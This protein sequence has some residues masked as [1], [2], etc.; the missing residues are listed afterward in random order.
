MKE[1]VG[2]IKTELIEK[3]PRSLDLLVERINTTV[4]PPEPVTTGDVYIRAMY[5]VSDQINSYGGCFPAE[6][7]QRLIEL[8]IDSPVMV[9]HRKDQLPIARNFSAEMVQKNGVNWIKVYFYWLKNADGGD[10]L[11]R[12][13]DGGI[14]KEGSISF[15]F[16]FPECSIC[17]S[18]IRDCGHRP[19]AEYSVDGQMV[20]AY[21]NYR[22][23]VKVLETSLVYRGSISGTAITRELL[24]KPALAESEGKTEK[25]GSLPSINFICDLSVLNPGNQYFIMPAYESL[26]VQI[27]RSSGKV[28]FRDASGNL[29]GSEALGR[30][31]ENLSWPKGEYALTGRLIGYRGKERQKIAELV[32]YLGTEKSDVKRLELKITDL[33]GDAAPAERKAELKKLFVGHTGFLIRGEVVSGKNLAE[34]VNRWSSRYGVEIHDHVSDR[35]YHYSA[36]NLLPLELVESEKHQA[37]YKYRLQTVN[38]DGKN[39]VKAVWISSRKLPP[40]GMVE[41]EVAGF[42]KIGNQYSLIQPRFFDYYPAGLKKSRAVLSVGDDCGSHE[43][44]LYRF[45]D[46]AAVLIFD[47]DRE[48]SGYK[49]ERFSSCLLNSGRRFLVEKLNEIMPNALQS[50]GR[51]KIRNIKR[52]EPGV[53]FKATGVLTGRLVIRPV[54]LNGVER[55]VLQKVVQADE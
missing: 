28:I 14:Y 31:S 20:K 41:M 42:R 17:G 39:P 2:Q 52:Y 11:R 47:D 18:D 12:N 55:L 15:L 4:K 49:I 51:G 53:A 26:P 21:F 46:Q 35:W 43:Y 24:F 3:E 9:G 6:E 7:H 50:I 48:P 27:E 40:G 5:L 38:S 29:L 36:R 25:T 13:I 33:R 16:N 37:G 44:S 22:Q 19:L 45:N 32:K 34:S 23:V 1:L 8:L 30:F 54:K 10:D